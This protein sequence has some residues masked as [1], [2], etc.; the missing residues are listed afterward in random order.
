MRFNIVF[1]DIR[2][3][4]NSSYG[5]AIKEARWWP[6]DQ[7]VEAGSK[8]SD[9]LYKWSA[10]KYNTVC[11]TFD[12]KMV[13][14]DPKMLGQSWKDKLCVPIVEYSGGSTEITIPSA[15][16]SGNATGAGAPTEVAAQP[17]ANV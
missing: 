9:N 17:G 5:D 16:T 4:T 3:E 8:A 1:K 12:P 10:T 7:T 6:D 14:G 11:T 13:S 15:A 2:D